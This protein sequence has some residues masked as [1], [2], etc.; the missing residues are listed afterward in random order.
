[1]RNLRQWGLGSVCTLAWIL[2]AWAQAPQVPE[3]R[4]QARVSEVVDGD[5]VHLQPVGGRQEIKARLLG[6]DAPE[7]CQSFGHEAHNALARR[8]TDKVVMVESN[9]QDDYGRALT[10]IYLNGEDMGGWLVRQGLAWSY[11]AGRG[12]GPYRMDEA[13]ARAARRGLFVEPD[14]MK[15][16][17]FRRKYKSCYSHG[18][19]PQLR[20][21]RSKYSD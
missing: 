11:G 7:I 12:K 6:I 8:L 3:Q 10:R 19:T 9:R 4:Y 16:S 17:Q 1:M 20:S 18:E 2:T 14:A 5:T 15:P 21:K 13:E